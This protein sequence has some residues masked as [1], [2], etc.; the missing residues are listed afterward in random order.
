LILRIYNT[1]NIL[2]PEGRSSICMADIRQD[3]VDIHHAVADI[4]DGAADVPNGV[5]DVCNN[6]AD[7]PESVADACNDI[8]DAAP[9][10]RVMPK[11][12]IYNDKTQLPVC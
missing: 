2:K 9:W 7:I 11:R 3:A 4:P 12:L 10:R 5:A 6:A 1:V 8:A